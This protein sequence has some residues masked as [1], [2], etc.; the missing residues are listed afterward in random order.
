[1]TRSH[2]ED[3]GR[4]LKRLAKDC[5]FGTLADFHREALERWLAALTGEGMSART[6]NAYL[7]AIVSFCNWC[8]ETHRLAVNPFDA[9]PKANEQADPR[10][11][12]RAMTEAELVKLLATVR[13]RPLLDAL[14]VRKGPRKGERYA[15]VRPQ[16]QARLQLLGRERALIY[17]TLILTG[18]RKSELASLT[19]AQLHV[20]D[21]VPYLSL[22]AADEKNREGNDIPLRDD[23]AADLRGWLADKLHRLQEEALRAGAPIPARLPPDTPLFAV[24]DRLVMILD[25]DLRLAGIAKRDDRGRTLDVHALR[26]T[27]GTLL[28]KGG[29]APGTAQ[30][31]MRHSDIKLTMNVY[32]DPAL[33]DVRGALDALPLLP[34]GGESAEREA[35]RATGTGSGT[36]GTSPPAGRTGAPVYEPVAAVIAAAVLC[37][38]CACCWAAAA[39][40]TCWLLAAVPG[41]CQFRRLRHVTFERPSMDSP[42]ERQ[43]H[44]GPSLPEGH[45]TLIEVLEG[46]CVPTT[47]TP[48]TFTDGGLGSGSLRD[49]VLRFNADAGTDDDVIQLEAGTYSRPCLRKESAGRQLGPPPW[50]C[51]STF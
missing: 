41:L 23:L 3:T 49:A 19:V 11:Q 47:I 21:P 8:V 46:R 28:S 38:S 22:D 24:P 37:C 14:T 50:A 17:K 45:C 30:A 27:F 43:V 25:R 4:Y 12:R 44:A 42:H 2:R 31:A 39:V 51:S 5:C 15:H 26:H 6:R 10:R 1:V 13:E 20:D 36:A 9:V 32:T 16:G 7:N 40:S 35:E 48:R 29:V 34:L 33:L 18:L